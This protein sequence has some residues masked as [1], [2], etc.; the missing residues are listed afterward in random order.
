VGLF[1]LWLLFWPATFNLEGKGTLEPTFK[2][3]VFA[4]VDGTVEDVL[5]ENGDFVKKGQELARLR[6]NDLTNSYIDMKGKLASTRDQITAARHGQKDKKRDTDSHNEVQ[7][8]E[9]TQLEKSYKDQL[10]TLEEKRAEL[11]IRSPIDGQINSWKVK[12]NL[13]ARTVKAGQVLMSVADPAGDW[14][15]EIHMPEDHIGFVALAQKERKEAGQSDELPVTFVLQSNAADWHD[16]HVDEVHG[17]AEVRQEEGNTVLVKVAFDKSQLRPSDL[18]SGATV[19]A[20]IDCGTVS[21]GYKYFHSVISFIQTKI[22]F[23]LW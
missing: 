22:L 4:A 23:K 20:K 2:R 8:A 6:N 10:R 13:L 1:L 12:E 11:V 15:L 16:G 18:R 7:L 19:S 5:V 9:L 3:D 17:H 21:I 14:E